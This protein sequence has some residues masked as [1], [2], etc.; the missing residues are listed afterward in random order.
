MTTFN[1]DDLI[2]SFTEEDMQDTLLPD[3]I[4]PDPAQTEGYG[5]QFTGNVIYSNPMASRL[6]LGA[7]DDEISNP[8]YDRF[9]QLK[10]TQWEP[11]MSHFIYADSDEEVAQEKE[12]LSKEI[13]LANTVMNSGWV[14]TV[15]MFAGG[16]A[17]PTLMVPVLGA[18]SKVRTAAQISKLALEGSSYTAAGMAASE[19]GLHQSQ[20]IRTTEQSLVNIASS[21]VLGGVLGVAVGGVVAGKYKLAD[22]L[23]N[24]ILKTGEM[25]R[26]KENLSAAKWEPS[27]AA[28]AG[29]PGWVAKAMTIPGLRAPIIEGLTSKSPLLKDI[30]SRLFENNLIKERNR[31]GIKS[32][33]EVLKEV[34]GDRAKTAK[35]EGNKVV[36]PDGSR[37]TFS[38]TRS[39]MEEPVNMETLLKQDM[40]DSLNYRK[41]MESNYADYLKTKSGGVLGGERAYITA[42][43]TG[44]MTA[45]EMYEE[46][47]KWSRRLEKSGDEFI[48]KGVQLYRNMLAV[49][50][51]KMKALAQEGNVFEQFLGELELK[52][53]QAYFTIVP[54]K[55]KI[56]KNR[57]ELENAVAEYYVNAKGMNPIEARSYASEH[58]DHFIG[59]DGAGTMNDL[60]QKFVSIDKGV[61]FTKSRAWDVPDTILEP[62]LVNDA[63]SIGQ[64]YI[65]MS[66][67][68]ARFQQFLDQM[69]ATNLS[70]LKQRLKNEYES[71]VAKITNHP[72][73]N[74][75]K[76]KVEIDYVHNAK[77]LDDFAAIALGQF[78][79]KGPADKALRFLRTYNY[80]RLMGYIVLSSITDLAMP[81]FK[82]G[83]GRTIMDGYVS[84][85]KN[86]LTGAR[87]LQNKDLADLYAALDIEMSNTLRTIMDPE[88]TRSINSAGE[89]INV[90]GDWASE[91]FGKLSGIDYWNTMHKRMA[92][93]MTISRLVRDMKNYSGLSS[94]EKEFLNSA[95]IGESNIKAILKEIE[96]HAQ[97]YNGAFITNINE[98]SNTEAKEVFRG[99]VIKEVDSTIVTPSRGD[100]PRLIQRSEIARTLFQFKGFFSAMTTKVLINGMQRRDANVLQGVLALLALGGAQYNLR[101]YMMNKEVNNNPSNLLLESMNRSGLLG[102]MG[103]PVFGLILRPYITSSRYMN[104]SAVEYPLGPSASLIK[105]LSK[106]YADSMKLDFDDKTLKAMGHLTPFQ[107][108]FWLRLL[109]DKYFGNEEGKK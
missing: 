43:R 84:G 12:R 40:S 5:M 44:K 20:Q 13:E 36:Y 66:N 78:N 29:L 14:G 90:Y 108:L 39:A 70:D 38:R 33:A 86:F 92:A 45:K 59:L 75:L 3:Q 4:K 7:K 9:S 34:A 31:V 106:V 95:G 98:W 103:D 24:H 32:D 27:D 62:G 74:N 30:A 49:Q 100:M 47:G 8:S 71:Q 35:I 1:H 80:L 58:M 26:L 52:G 54:D 76:G 79:R 85:V 81:I 21:A 94:A 89:K 68:M 104:Q 72:D 69:G 73:Y 56:I 109:I 22:S 61:R 67:K 107:N 50:N 99:A 83:L 64:Q 37:E 46:I 25:P 93:R 55:A 17:D 19:V 96:V 91:K 63:M 60:A 102:L 28:I 48:D 88:F 105:D 16:L 82:Q 97:E 18:V 23:V 2:K 53:R 10:D 77:L 57:A 6:Y 51:K 41:A 101:M 87:K 11:M 65:E 15:G 42:K